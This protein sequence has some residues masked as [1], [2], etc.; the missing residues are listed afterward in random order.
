[1][2]GAEGAA[3]SQ[4]PYKLLQEFD[5]YF[6]SNEKILTDFKEGFQFMSS[7]LQ[8]DLLLNFPLSNTPK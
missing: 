7:C 2:E 6:Q 4:G 5:L 8:Y 3:R 1:M